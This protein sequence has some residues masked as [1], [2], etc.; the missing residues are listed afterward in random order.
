MFS[1]FRRKARKYSRVVTAEAVDEV[2]DKVSTGL[3]EQEPVRMDEDVQKDPEEQNKAAEQ[4]E[5]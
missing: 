2:I 1:M 5:T 3:T 4:A